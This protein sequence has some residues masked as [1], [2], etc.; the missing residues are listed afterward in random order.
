MSQ[1]KKAKDIEFQ[2]RS[3]AQWGLL[4]PVYQGVKLQLLVNEAIV[5]F[6]LHITSLFLMGSKGTPALSTA[7]TCSQ[8]CIATAV[9]NQRFVSVTSQSHSRAGS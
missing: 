1:V 4:L 5:S 2:S 6:W 3:L 8:S 7:L 9:L